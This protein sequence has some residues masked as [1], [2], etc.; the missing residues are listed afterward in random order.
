MDREA[1]ALESDVQGVL[2]EN[3]ERS[4]AASE[5]GLQAGDVIVEVDRTPVDSVDEAVK[6]SSAFKGRVI[7]LR[8]FSEGRYA[9]V[10]VRLER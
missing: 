10:A 7:M 3:V 2:V 4:S 6:K 5:A 9:L 8:V 1:L